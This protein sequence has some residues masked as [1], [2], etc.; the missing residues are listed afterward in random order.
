MK[1]TATHRGR[2]DDSFDR[3]RRPNN[4]SANRSRDKLS[5]PWTLFVNVVFV[6]GTAKVLPIILGTTRIH[7]KPSDSISHNDKITMYKKNL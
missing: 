1:Y 2:E 5:V 4:H 7:R 3:L 6:F